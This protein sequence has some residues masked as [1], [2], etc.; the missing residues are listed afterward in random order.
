MIAP[1]FTRAVTA[2]FSAVAVS[3]QLQL[4]YAQQ[5]QAAE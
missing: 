4:V 1:R 5:Q 2:V 3:D